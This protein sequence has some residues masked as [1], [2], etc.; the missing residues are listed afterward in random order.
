[1]AERYGG[2]GARP[3]G[4]FLRGERFEGFNLSEAGGMGAELEILF[5]ILPDAVEVIE[6][7]QEIGTTMEWTAPTAG[8]VVRDFEAAGGDVEELKVEGGG[9]DSYDIVL[10]D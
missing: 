1:V 8:I 9:F 6:V 7:V 2:L 4:A 3:G 10:L 5:Q